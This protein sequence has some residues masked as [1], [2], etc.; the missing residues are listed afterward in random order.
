LGDTL[1][2]HSL[3]EGARHALSPTVHWLVQLRPLHPL[4]AVGVGIYLVAASGVIHALRPSHATKRFGQALAV[5]FVIQLCV[6]M[7]N[8]LLRAPVL[9]QIV[10]L[11]LADL[12]WI[13]LVLLTAAALAQK[14][15]RTETVEQLRPAPQIEGN[16]R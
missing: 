3:T 1:F 13:A 4:L 9:M 7:L 10:H 6:G 16:P 8:V 11:L 5:L 14:A 15:P 12:V 2:P